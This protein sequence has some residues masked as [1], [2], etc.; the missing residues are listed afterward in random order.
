MGLSDGSPVPTLWR[1]FPQIH[2]KGKN[3]L[4]EPESFIIAKSHAMI[5][6]NF[7]ISI[8]KVK[9]ICGSLAADVRPIYGDRGV[10][11]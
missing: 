10:G 5:G 1:P 2:L 8:G 7:W 6:A 3:A 11:V 4:C 9:G